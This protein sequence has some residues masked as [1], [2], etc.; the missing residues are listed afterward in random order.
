VGSNVSYRLSKL[1][2]R[3]LLDGAWLDCG[4]GDGSYTFCRALS[5]DVTFGFPI[6]LLPWPPSKLAMRFM[7]AR[8]YWPGEL[9]YPV[10]CAGFDI[11]SMSSIFP[12]FE[13]YPWLPSRA[14]RVYRDVLPTLD[15]VPAIRRFGISTL[16][17]ARPG[18][19]T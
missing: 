4:C 10:R 17:V 7:R 15:R 16:I 12:V 8:N 11:L 5:E 2:E 1:R 19:G 9:R 6:P 18:D 3:V 14:I 13:V